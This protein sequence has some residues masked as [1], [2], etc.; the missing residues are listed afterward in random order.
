MDGRQPHVRSAPAAGSAGAGI[1]QPDLHAGSARVGLEP[2]QRLLGLARDRRA[3]PLSPGGV[4]QIGEEGNGELQGA[5]IPE[6]GEE[7]G[8]E[9]REDI[10][11]KIREEDGQEVREEDGEEV[12]PEVGEDVHCTAPG[13]EEGVRARSGEQRRALDAEAAGQEARASLT[14]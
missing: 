14:R 12:R 10:S 4:P 2:R 11:Q 6:V 3:P 9:G 13:Q 7:V 1:L 8:E 5:G